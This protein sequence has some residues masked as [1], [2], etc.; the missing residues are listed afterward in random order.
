MS[1]D[2]VLA[3]LMRLEDGVSRVQG[4]QVKLR[5]ELGGLK[6]GQSGLQGELSRLKDDQTKLRVDLM[7]RIDRLENRL[8]TIQDDIG[9]NMGGVTT[10]F[11]R[12]AATRKEVDST[13]L[14]VAGMMR[15]ILRLQTDVQDLKNKR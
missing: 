5:E 9:V 12:Q 11:E 8:T 1:G 14:L 6:E 3:A 4:E 7:E 15:Q 10:V 13:G 2:R